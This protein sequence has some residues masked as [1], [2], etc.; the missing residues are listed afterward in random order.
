VSLGGD[1]PI[2]RGIPYLYTAPFARGPRVIQETYV[3]PSNIKFVSTS[4]NRM[5]GGSD[6]AAKKA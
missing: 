1:V 5:F 3:N 2:S 4:G 6:V